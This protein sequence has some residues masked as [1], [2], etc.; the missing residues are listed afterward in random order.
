MKKFIISASL[1]L[2]VTIALPAIVLLA[3]SDS[4]Q[5]SLYQ[6]ILAKKLGS[7]KIAF[8][9]DSITADGLVW[10]LRIK[11]YNF[12]VWNFGRGGFETKQ[13]QYYAKKVVDYKSHYAFVMAGI[14]D[15]D[16]TLDGVKQSF[17][18]YKT[19]LDT[20]ING[21]V[22]PIIQ[23]TLFRENEENPNFIIELNKLLVS[24]AAEHRLTVINLNPILCPMNSLL[25]EYSRDGI[26][27]TPAAYNIWA[28]E[29]RKVL[30]EKQY[31]S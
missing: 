27:L 11:E 24:Y 2:N 29:I 19:L 13:M 17:E 8:I 1:I 28:K 21:G 16:K 4:I 5:Y 18:D 22:E 7:P 23:L 30:D 10:A 15:P 31:S 14:N 6:D 20:L 12:N 3:F 25:P 26:H 9:G